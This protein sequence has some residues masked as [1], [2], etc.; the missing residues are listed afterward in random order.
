MIR[1]LYAMAYAVICGVLCGITYDSFR[2]FRVFW[3]ITEYTK[4]GQKLYSAEFPLIGT[5]RRPDSG[6]IVR[7]AHFW[8]VL[9]GDILFAL[10]SGCIFSVFVYVA[11]SGCFR[12]FYLLFACVGFLVYYFT[13]GNLV[14]AASDVI[15]CILRI[16]LRYVLYFF[17]LPF[18]AVWKMMIVVQQ[19]VLIRVFYPIMRCIYR[20]RCRKYT[21]RAKNDLF[22]LI[23]I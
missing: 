18:R 4:M 11:A 9:I 23:R 7:T 17:V 3:G 10:L 16:L 22:K 20:S 8:I 12:W 14:M 5:V 21:S 19:H 15:V 13:I 6:R 2:L 1:Q